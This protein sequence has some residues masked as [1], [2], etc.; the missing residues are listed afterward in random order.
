M[1]LSLTHWRSPAGPIW[2]LTWAWGTLGT[3]WHP[4][5]PLW[6]LWCRRRKPQRSSCII[7]ST[8]SLPHLGFW[9]CC[10]L[11]WSSCRIKFYL[12]RL[13][14]R[15]CNPR[16]RR[17]L[18]KFAA[19]SVRIIWAR[20]PSLFLPAQFPGWPSQHWLGATALC[21][22]LWTCKGVRYIFT[23]NYY[24]RHYCPRLKLNPI[25]CN[26]FFG[27]PQ[28]KRERPP[29]KKGV[30][31]CSQHRV[32]DIFTS[33]PDWIHSPSLNWN[34]LQVDLPSPGFQCVFS[35]TM[36]HLLRPL[37]VFERPRLPINWTR[38]ETWTPLDWC[39]SSLALN[40]KVLTPRP[41]LKIGL[42]LP[43]EDL[44]RI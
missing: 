40:S 11:F 9:W 23:S 30:S 2:V 1:T 6:S 32:G 29:N 12:V 10:V 37:M 24:N 20:N 27:R 17:R 44:Q 19:A 39:E 42:D 33:W 31:G 22:S 5:A 43:D 4:L 38:Q 28:K 7:T 16:R 13:D 35:S 25:W 41:C 3:L 15:P 34:T 8:L 21:L 26:R 14:Y 18:S 36:D